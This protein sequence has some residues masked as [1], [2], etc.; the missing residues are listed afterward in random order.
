[1][2]KTRFTA[3]FLILIT[4]F[5]IYDLYISLT[6]SQIPST[7]SVIAV[8]SFFVFLMNMLVFFGTFGGS[9]SDRDF[10]FALPLPKKDL[11]ASMYITRFL[12]IGI[13]FIFVM[14]YLVPGIQGS[15]SDKVIV[16]VNIA[17]GSLL[18]TAIATASTR[19][20]GPRKAALSIFF[21]VWGILAIPY[22]GL[23]F[24]Y[25]SA[26]NGS[27]LYGTVFMVAVNIPMNYF[28]LK[29]VY[30]VE[31]GVSKSGYSSS[32]E[33][34]GKGTSFGTSPSS[35]IIKYYFSNINISGRTNM[36]GN[37]TVTSRGFKLRNGFIVTAIISVIYFLITLRTPISS[38]EPFNM[39]IFLATGYVGVFAPLLLTS[40]VIS[41]ERAWLSFVALSPGFYM[42]NLLLSKQ[43]QVFV[44]LLPF[45]IASVILQF[46]G[47]VGAVNSAIVSGIMAPASASIFL[48]LSTKATVV[49]IKDTEMMPA[50]YSLKQMFQIMPALF[51][52]ILA[53]ISAVFLVMAIISSA[54]VL[55]IS[56]YLMFR[57][58]SW[59]KSVSVLTERGFV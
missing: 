56:A 34:K 8:F 28:A 59:N 33:M 57:S 27:L 1:M 39:A 11:V 31:L 37:V 53:Y 22:V 46:Y 20:S 16:I 2:L 50:R 26:L 29:S 51:L 21:T 41:F 44:L 36:G 5:I 47:V 55:G 40:G 23:K 30:D 6:L 49:Q 13:I 15:L 12:S 19:L 18:L 48:F 43:L 32:L 9:K 14:G 25:L 24:S 58:K 35:S 4:V 10:L 38:S 17:L 52:F 3:P 45:T 54:L 42:R 7:F